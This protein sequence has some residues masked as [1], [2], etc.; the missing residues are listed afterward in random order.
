LKEQLEHIKDIVD[1]SFS[2]RCMIKLKEL[3]Y[4][5]NAIEDGNRITREVIRKNDNIS[6]ILKRQEKL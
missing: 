5:F 2:P 1:S 3:R 4:L 6:H